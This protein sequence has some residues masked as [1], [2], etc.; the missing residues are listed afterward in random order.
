MHFTGRF[1]KFVVL[2]I[3]GRGNAFPAYLAAGRV[4]PSTKTP[5]A[6]A[7]DRVTAGHM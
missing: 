6:L 1:A 7:I 3:V 4:S 5:Q 2:S